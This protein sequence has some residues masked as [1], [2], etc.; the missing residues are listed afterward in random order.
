MNA[1]EHHGS[2]A[3][4][5]DCLAQTVSLLLISAVVVFLASGLPARTFFAG[6]SGVKLIATLNA[7]RHPSRPLDIDLPQVAGRPLP[8]ID[9]FFRIRGDHAHATT[10]ELFPLISAPFVALFG[11]RGA[12]VLPAIGF[13][14]AILGIGYVGKRLDPER[15][16]VLLFLVAGAATPLLFYGLEFWEHAPAVG[17]AAIST[18]LLLDSSLRRAFG[19]GL[20]AGLAVLLR[21]E[22]LWY[23]AGLFVASTQLSSEFR[24][25]SIAYFAIGFVTLISPAMLFS[26]FHGESVVGGHV[27]T[28]LPDLSAH[29]WP[30]RLQLGERW[31]NPGLPLFRLT[32]VIAIGL[33]VASSIDWQWADRCL[34]GSM[35]LAAPITL[36]AAGR[37]VPLQS[38]WCGAPIAAVLVFASRPRQS[39]GG[40]F[41]VL[42]LVVY[43]FGVVLTAPNDGGA[44]FSPRYLLLAFV[45]AAVL[46]ADALARTTSRFKTIGTVVVAT[47]ILAGIAVQRAAYKDLQGAKNTYERIVMLVQQNTSPGS[48]VVS[49]LW[50]LDQVAAALYPSRTF[51]YIGN[52]YD[53]VKAV[54]ALVD[55][56]QRD[57]AVV[58]SAS[59]SIA[60][61][62]DSLTVRA[63]RRTDC[64]RIRERD[65]TICHFRR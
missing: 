41:L 63:W 5:Q 11:I 48:Y 30:L 17:A 4:R 13:L 51:L 1:A 25:S 29:W 58:S 46:V 42:L 21:P 23:V 6:D 16:V 57:V 14:G 26:L 24:R 62:A 55:S 45:P 64:V 44:E 18:G 34:A 32:S 22:A 40:T 10:S 19:A 65:L 28:N 43:T 39:T 47:T 3:I 59:E 27:L 15:S 2:P 36:A 20:F 38:V 61:V 60:G 31:L 54:D 8:L 35:F 56:R 33:A 9:P 37:A 49:D 12:Y 50:W 52:A 7:I 53:A